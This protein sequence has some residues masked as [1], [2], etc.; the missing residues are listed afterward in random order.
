[1]LKKKKKGWLQII[2]AM[3]GPIST[4]NIV[5]VSDYLNIIRVEIIFEIRFGDFLSGKLIINFTISTNP[6][7]QHYNIIYIHNQLCTMHET[8]R[9][10]L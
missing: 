6:L 7:L 8:F 2:P 1:M 5:H 10:H 9:A 3:T 4:S